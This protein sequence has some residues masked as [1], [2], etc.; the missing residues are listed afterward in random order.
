MCGYF[1][2]SICTLFGLGCLWVLF[3]IDGTSDGPGALLFYIGAGG[4]LLMGVPMLFQSVADTLRAKLGS[5]CND[6]SP[7]P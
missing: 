4:G 5:E 2:G 1:F 6:E 7:W 3:R